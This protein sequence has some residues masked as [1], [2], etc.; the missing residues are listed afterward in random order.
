[1]AALELPDASH[2]AAINTS[3]N[4]SRAENPSQKSYVSRRGDVARFLGIFT[5]SRDFLVFVRG[6]NERRIFQDFSKEFSWNQ[7]I[8]NFLEIIR[9]D[10]INLLCVK[11]NQES[12]RLIN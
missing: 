2:P 10:M 8:I 1:M 6:K 4:Y 12:K 7:R 3:I 9:R 5:L 11:F